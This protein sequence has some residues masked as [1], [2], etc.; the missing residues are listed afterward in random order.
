MKT[1]DKPYVL[2]LQAYNNFGLID[3][4]FHQGSR[5]VHTYGGACE[6]CGV[7]TRSC[8]Y[9][10]IRC[11]DAELMRRGIDLTKGGSAYVFARDDRGLYRKQKGAE[12]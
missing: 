7:P 5:G 10:C 12:Q 1:T 9:Y 4:A 2:P 6:G 11:I 8:A 3:I